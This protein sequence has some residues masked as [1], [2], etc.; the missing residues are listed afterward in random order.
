LNRKSLIFTGIG[1][2]A[3][4]LIIGFVMIGRWLDNTYSW[5]GMGTAA[6][7]VIAMVVWLTHVLILLKQL[8][9]ADKSSHTDN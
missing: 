8:A 4:G 9:K 5:G 6:G 1:F 7:G 3:I 2:E